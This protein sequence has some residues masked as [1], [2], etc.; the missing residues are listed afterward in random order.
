M[1]DEDFLAAGAGG[2]L[3][4]A[5][6]GFRIGSG[7]Q[8]RARSELIGVLGQQSGREEVKRQAKL[9]IS[10]GKEKDIPDLD[11][12]QDA[13]DRVKSLEAFQ[14]TAND[15]LKFSQFVKNLGIP[16]DKAPE[17]FRVSKA[18]LKNARDLVAKAT[19]LK[20][21]IKNVPN[22]ENSQFVVTRI[23]DDLSN[24]K[25]VTRLSVDPDENPLQAIKEINAARPSDYI[26]LDKE[27]DAM[28]IPPETKAV[29]KQG[30]R[31]AY[32]Y[33]ASRVLA[34]VSEGGGGGEAQ[35][36]DLAA[37][38]RGLGA[39]LKNRVL[40]GDI[41]GITNSSEFA[42]FAEKAASQLNAS[43][44][45]VQIAQKFPAGLGDPAAQQ[46]LAD[47][48]GPVLA[49]VYVGA[50]V[51]GP[52]EA[53]A[54][55]L[56]GAI[57]GNLPPARLAGMV[58]D[59]PAV[60]AIRAAAS[61][62][63]QNF[64]RGQVRGTRTSLAEAEKSRQTSAL[65]SI[66]PEGA[67]IPETTAAPVGAAPPPPVIAGAPL[68]TEQAALQIP[69]PPPAGLAPTA[70]AGAP[71]APAVPT[72]G[73]AQQNV[74]IQI[75]QPGT[76]PTPDA[77]RFLA[78]V[79]QGAS[80]SMAQAVRGA[81]NAQQAVAAATQAAGPVV[82]QY[83]AQ[84]RSADEV[85]EATRSLVEQ[86]LASGGF[87]SQDELL[88]PSRIADL[89]RRREIATLGLQ[90]DESIRDLI[91]Q[92]GPRGETGLEP[93]GQQALLE[94]PEGGTTTG[95]PELDQL[96]EQIG[97]QLEI[98][99]SGL[100]PESPAVARARAGAAGAAL[101]PVQLSTPRLVQGI[102]KAFTSG[103]PLSTEQSRY[104]ENAMASIFE[105]DD[106]QE[107]GAELGVGGEES[108]GARLTV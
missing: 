2:A 8:E 10:T 56:V 13:R 96:A 6:Q 3:G 97:A 53:A 85:F 52:A 107:I 105:D 100:A 38:A 78:D 94:I 77:S 104:L 88:N 21:G 86:A 102:S 81:R 20:Y 49:E 5:F 67:A 32:E 4:G 89:G 54:R 17:L 65:A 9:K 57:G 91:R 46:L 39:R 79:E 64:A 45:G 80:E 43:R 35:A 108:G 7:T 12:T 72:P 47:A 63:A 27:V 37:A 95:S 40:G 41:S 15:S 23:L 68:G 34:A 36:P 24:P 55:K 66:Y 42:N 11:F 16:E 62:A 83:F 30:R 28:G 18:E 103:E 51:I 82:G 70:V 58:L 90:V 98:G 50:G 31:F 19:A 25:Y 87:A 48:L 33:A 92:S 29:L 61:T 14:E 60:K 99:Q 69:A 75:P 74:P 101:P 26:K 22:F 44:L 106:L 93:G 1:A 84:G 71:G 76:T 59:T 73:A